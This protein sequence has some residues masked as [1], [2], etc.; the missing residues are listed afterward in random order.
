MQHAISAAPTAAV[1]NKDATSAADA[2]KEKRM[3]ELKEKFELI[4]LHDNY[5]Y[6]LLEHFYNTSMKENFP[7]EDELDP[8]EEWVEGLTKNDNDPILP[9]MHVTILIDKSKKHLGLK[10]A[11]IG[12]MMYEYYKI[13]NVGLFS[14][15]CINKEYRQLKLGDFLAHEAYLGCK[16]V[17]QK[18]L[19]QSQN[20][21][22]YRARVL[23]K[24]LND[25]LKK[26]KNL[27]AETEFALQYLNMLLP[28]VFKND[29]HYST[30]YCFFAETNMLHL[31]DGVMESATRHKIMRSIGFR[32][33]D[34]DFIQ[35]PL[36]SEQAP[37]ADLLLLAYDNEDIPVDYSKSGCPV[38][39]KSLGQ[40][41][42][43][44]VIAMLFMLD[45]AFSIGEITVKEIISAPYF[46]HVMADLAKRDAK[47]HLHEVKHWDRKSSF[48]VEQPSKL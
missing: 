22:D 36:S 7:I 23:L 33:L 26:D 35:P 13:S 15:F 8:L 12:G 1:S 37:C 39:A 10:N 3:R 32:C 34:F 17:A 2:K 6:D 9:E 4:D 28:F 21:K 48:V 20:Q 41:Y 44:S 45:Y 43:P 40:K 46:R 31:S 38:A 19:Q 29:K 30:F 16:R 5:N 24:S 27:P 25:A 42:V 18:F 14:Y 47:L 11:I